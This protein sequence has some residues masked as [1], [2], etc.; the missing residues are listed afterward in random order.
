[1][2]GDLK[3]GEK[4]YRRGK[5][6]EAEGGGNFDGR[7]FTP[8]ECFSMAIQNDVESDVYWN[9]LGAVGGG[10]ITL[11]GKTREVGAKDCHI[12]AL[13]L[14]P[15]NDQAWSNLGVHG[16]TT[17]T[18]NVGLGDF[19]QK[20]C[21]K[22]AIELNPRNN[23]AWGNMGSLLY[24][25]DKHKATIII[26]LNE[27]EV[28]FTIEDCK[29]KSLEFSLRDPTKNWHPLPKSADA[30]R[31]DRRRQRIKNRKRK[32]SMKPNDLSELRKLEANSTDGALPVFWN[33]R[34]AGTA[35]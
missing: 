11:L 10:T 3:E 28:E 12:E 16:G 1:M 34:G 25:E 9:A 2:R 30:K 15:K 27:E 24:S 29:M 23:I 4:W 31:N 13:K 14:N 26:V 35:I 7:F 19:S 18:G 5:S 6:V 32:N 22:K 8:A 33:S 20:T 21:F 17:G